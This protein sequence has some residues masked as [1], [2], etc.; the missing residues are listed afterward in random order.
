MTSDVNLSDSDI[1]SNNASL[2]VIFHQVYDPNK[3]C[4]TLLLP[5]GA[6]LDNL[7]AALKSGSARA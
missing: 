5:E 4:I 1:V 6:E 2:A 3:Y 7:V